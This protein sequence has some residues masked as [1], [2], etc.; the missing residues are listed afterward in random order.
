M[1]FISDAEEEESNFERLLLALTLEA[2]AAFV[3]EDVCFTN[4]LL[5]DS[6][7][8][9]LLLMATMDDELEFE[10]AITADD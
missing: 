6:A 2:E 1:L 9:A 4:C 3:P 5:L 8:F 7:D 10:V